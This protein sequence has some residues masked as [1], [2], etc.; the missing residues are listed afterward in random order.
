MMTDNG[1]AQSELEN[2]IERIR[3]VSATIG[4]PVG[5]LAQTIQTLIQSEADPYLLA[6]VLVEGAVQAVVRRV[7]QERRA[8]VSIAL[9]QLMA[10][11]LRTETPDDPQSG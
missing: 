6:G 2:L 4:D 11:R 10:D 5:D 7:P 8:V 9:L 3:Q 1:C